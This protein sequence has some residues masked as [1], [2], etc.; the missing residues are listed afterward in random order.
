MVAAIDDFIAAETR[1]VTRDAHPLTPMLQTGCEGDFQ[2]VHYRHTLQKKKKKEAQH[3]H[4]PSELNKSAHCTHRVI[5]GDCV[6][7]GDR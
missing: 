2:E 1:T 5:E 6:C 4:A 7:F 3:M